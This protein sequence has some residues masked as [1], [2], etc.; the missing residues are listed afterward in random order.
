MKKFYMILAAV[1]ALTITAQ[2]QETGEIQVGDPESASTYNGSYFDMSPTNFYLAH[3][4]SQMIFTPDVLADLDGK[5]NVK[6]TQ[7]DFK[8]Y[9]ESYEEIERNV[10]IYLQE[11]DATQFAVVDGK[12]QFFQL[13]ELVYDDAIDVD[14]LEGYGEDCYLTFPLEFDFTPGSGL[15]VTIVFDAEDD[16]NCTMGSDYAPF[17]SSGITGKAMTYTSNWTSFVDYA[18]G[19]DFPDATAMLGCG[20]NVDLPLTNISYTYDE[21]QP[22]AINDL[23]EGKTVAA[24]RYYGIDGKPM[25]QPQGIAIAVTTYTDGTTESVK[26]VK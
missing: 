14:L 21:P 18:E 1:A 6:I 24:V 13:G 11:T 16:D 17:Y 19:D 20:T 22:T 26:I 10:K 25:S 5:E 7:L 8:F 3:T 9:S 12:K 23:S 15:I 2:A 4:G